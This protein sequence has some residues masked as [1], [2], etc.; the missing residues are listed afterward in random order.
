MRIKIGGKLT[1]AF[2][3]GYSPSPASITIIHRD[4]GVIT[5][6]ADEDQDVSTISLE[7]GNGLHL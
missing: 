2:G 5:S 1:Q 6:W 7:E 4:A 3:W